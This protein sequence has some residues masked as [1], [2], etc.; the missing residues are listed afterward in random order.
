MTSEEKRTLERKKERE[1]REREE[2]L[3]S[4]KKPQTVEQFDR[5]VL[6]RPNSSLIWINYMAY[7]LQATE[8]EKSRTI[9]RRALKTIDYTEESERLNIWFAWLN[10]ESRFGTI[11][12]LNDVFQ[13][14][15]KAN[16][17]FKVY[18]HMLTIHVEANRNY[19]LEKIVNTMIPKFKQNIESWTNCG[20]ALLK[21]GLKD[22]SRSIMQKAL[23]SL[24]VNKHIDLMI[25][26]A[27][28]EN[29]FGEKER[30]QT[31]FEQVLSQYPKRLD[32]WS[33]YVDSVVKSGD[34]EIARKIFSRAISQ[35]LPAKKM[36][37]ILKKYLNFEEIHGTTET[38]SNVQ[39]LIVK[40]VEGVCNES[41]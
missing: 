23:Q 20:A 40:Y 24:P 14:A 39:Q 6:S 29:K 22:K 35:T 19:E 11:E 7:H 8:F 32:V 33:A 38:V 1:I 25:K 30:S 13:E 5:L 15:I 18:S 27:H 10:L 12:S 26:F 37:I 4:S 16:D 36:K 31:L 2:F 21:A 9:A 34:I 3:A 17:A 41:N 28:F